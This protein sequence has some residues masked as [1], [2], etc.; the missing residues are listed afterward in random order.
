VLAGIVHDEGELLL[1]G[2]DTIG[3]WDA[4][5]DAEPALTV[6]LSGEQFDEALL[7]IANFVDLKS[8]YT[9]GHAPAVAGL[10]TAASSS[11]GSTRQA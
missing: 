9:L 1:A 5:I 6:M 8:P 10:A 7:A 2:L 3:T 4:V 11:S